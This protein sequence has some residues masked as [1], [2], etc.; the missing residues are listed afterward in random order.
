[1]NDSISSFSTSI[2]LGVKTGLRLRRQ[3]SYT[4]TNTN[5]STPSGSFIPSPSFGVSSYGVSSGGGIQTTNNIP[6]TLG[7]DEN[8]K[9]EGGSDNHSSTSPIPAFSSS[10]SIAQS[11]STTT[12]WASSR[13]GI[14]KKNSI[15]AIHGGGGGGSTWSSPPPYSS[16][17]SN[18]NENV[19][20]SP[21]ASFMMALNNAAT[22]ST[23]SLDS[24][25]GILYFDYM[26]RL[27]CM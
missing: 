4:S 3:S 16:N 1:M 13:I 10:L 17:G 14:K 20:M 2:P 15:N 22:F 5:T 23:G 26:V 18:E 8:D 6:F 12:T 9:S 19:A 7:S 21:A 24:G 25:Q 27:T 11:P